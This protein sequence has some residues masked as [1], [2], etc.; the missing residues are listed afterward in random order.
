MSLNKEVSDLQQKSLSLSKLNNNL[1]DIPNSQD[2]F[3]NEESLEVTK[4]RETTH[5]NLTKPI[6]LENTIPKKLES[7]ALSD[8]STRQGSEEKRNYYKKKMKN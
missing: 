1:D 6:A 2:I 5:E 7:D 4:T 8:A 3:Q